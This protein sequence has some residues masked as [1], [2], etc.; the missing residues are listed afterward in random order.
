MS[1]VVL[2][3]YCNE[4]VDL[5]HSAGYARRVA[6]WELVRTGGGLNAL[7]LREDLG[8]VMHRGCLERLK[9]G[10]SKDQTEFF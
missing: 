2:C 4:S 10:I 8:E 7:A 3:E 1:E 9:M 5:S 6:G